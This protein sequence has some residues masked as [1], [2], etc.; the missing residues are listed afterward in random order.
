MQNRALMCLGWGKRG[1]GQG[2]SF[3]PTCWHPCWTRLVYLWQGPHMDPRASSLLRALV[4]I[5][6]MQRNAQEPQRNAGFGPP[7]Q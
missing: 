1:T 5:S 2:L 6:P 3:P 4:L 7:L